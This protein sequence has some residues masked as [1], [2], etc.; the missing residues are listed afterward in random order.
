MTEPTMW[1]Y[2]KNMPVCD[3]QI[4]LCP[5]CLDLNRASHLI[6]PD[7]LDTIQLHIGDLLTC[8][9]CDMEFQ[10]IQLEPLAFVKAY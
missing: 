10:I 2:K 9:E 5:E 1:I 8:E 3:E 6:D 7:K 4:P